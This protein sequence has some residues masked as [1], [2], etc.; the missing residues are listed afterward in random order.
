MNGSKNEFK[1]SFLTV[2]SYMKVKRYFLGD[3]NDQFVVFLR[4]CEGE[5]TKEHRQSACDSL[6]PILIVFS[7]LFDLKEVLLFIPGGNN[8]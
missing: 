4:S 5:T 6:T 2:L 7:F 3:K 8:V 1:L